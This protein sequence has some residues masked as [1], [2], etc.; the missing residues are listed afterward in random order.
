MSIAVLAAA[1]AAYAQLSAI[2]VARDVV[3]IRL[4]TELS[5]IPDAALDAAKAAGSKLGAH[6][7]KSSRGN[8]V[9]GLEVPT[10]KLDEYCIYPIINAKTGGHMRTFAA[11][12]LEFI[13]GNSRDAR[14]TTGEVLVE[15]ALRPNG[16]HSMMEFWSNCIGDT[17]L[18]RVPAPSTGKFEQ[19]FVAQLSAITGQN[20]DASSLINTAMDAPAEEPY[21]FKSDFDPNDIHRNPLR[22]LHPG[23]SD[24]T[25]VSADVEADAAAV[26]KATLRSTQKLADLRGVPITRTD[27]KLFVVQNGASATDSGRG[28]REEFV[29]SLTS[30]GRGRVRIRVVRRLLVHS[31]DS[32]EWH[33]A[34]SDGEIESW[35]IGNIIGDVTGR[36][37][38]GQGAPVLERTAPPNPAPPQA[39]AGESTER[40]VPE[41]PS[42]PI[43]TP[44]VSTTE[45]SISSSVEN[46]DV[47]ID[48]N[49]VGNAPLP[50]F[51]LPAGVHTIV[52]QAMGYETWRRDL[53]V[54]TN[55]T[56]VV[57]QLRK[58]P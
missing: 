57:A 8:L 56:R 20:I 7:G 12:Q 58:M 36:E 55:A 53:T 17:E 28:W 49:F 11:W 44:Q 24:R 1:S 3:P 15:V 45:V 34:P 32:A 18:G 38:V 13:Q 22:A 35:L 16:D 48:G 31:R 4:T 21:K 47:Y 51:R 29:T 27:Q 33:G 54:A 41:S 40:R 14:R 42:T 37:V 19:S 2:P 46:A 39:V 6:M 30:E 43:A 50:S 25:A 52:V 9:V 26:W 5:M 23:V 10:S